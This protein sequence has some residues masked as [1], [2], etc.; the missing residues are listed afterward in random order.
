MVETAVC[1]LHRVTSSSYR[2]L[3]ETPPVEVLSVIFPRRCGACRPYR[4]AV[5]AIPWSGAD[6]RRELEQRGDKRI[7][8]S[9]SV[10]LT[11]SFPA[12]CDA[13]AQVE[14]LAVRSDHLGVPV[15]VRGGNCDAVDGAHHLE[16]RGGDWGTARRVGRGAVHR[17]L[18]PTQPAT[19]GVCTPEWRAILVGSRFVGAASCDQ[20]VP[21]ERCTA[22][23]TSARN[24]SD[25]P[26]PDG[27]DLRATS[28][29]VSGRI[30]RL[31]R[32]SHEG[33]GG[34]CQS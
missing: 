3:G 33:V 22:R 6:R 27:S 11:N 9:A 25:N 15:V 32:T 4:S 23:S 34:L 18:R 17:S 29:V 20:W 7:P 31:R 24:P 1:W 21:D 5:T 10:R 30:T 19:R 2:G 16:C 12:G 14:R 28:G 26:G 13:L 8:L